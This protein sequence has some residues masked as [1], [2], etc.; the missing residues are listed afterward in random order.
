MVVVMKTKQSHLI[1]GIVIGLGVA[2]AAIFVFSLGMFV[3]H[4]KAYFSYRWGENYHQ[5]FWGPPKFFHTKPFFGGH[6]VSGK[7]ISADSKQLIVQD[8]DNIEKIVLIM[9]ETEIVKDFQKIKI[10]EIKTGD[11][12]AVIGSPKEKDNGRIEARLIRLFPKEKVR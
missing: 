7:V 3:G 10:S 5:D 12:V 1:K 8:R 11:Y 2:F 9:D 6:G 4:K